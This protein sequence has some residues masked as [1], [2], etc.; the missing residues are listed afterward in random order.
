MFRHH[1]FQK[2]MSYVLLAVASFLWGKYTSSVWRGVESPKIIIQ[3][4]VVC[5]IFLLFIV[6]N[7]WLDYLCSDTLSSSSPN[8]KKG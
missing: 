3:A 5:S 1:N 8:K 7:V 4:A 2:R 6:L